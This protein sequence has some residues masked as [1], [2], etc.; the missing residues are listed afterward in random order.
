[1]TH[2]SPARGSTPSH[3]P[4]LTSGIL[5]AFMSIFASMSLALAARPAHA[6]DVAEFY[7]GKTVMLIVGSDAGGGYDIN[8]RVLAHYMARHIP[9]QPNIVV[10][11]MPGAIG[12]K[13]M[14]YIYSVAP[15]DG[16]VF[17]AAVNNMPYDPLFG[18]TASKFDTL[19]LNWLGSISKQTNVCLAWKGSRF[20]SLDDVTQH[21]MRVSGTGPAGWR[22]ML[23]L[24]FNSI[25]KTKF[26]VI[27]GYTSPG[28]MLAVER[29]EVDGICA[30]YATLKTAQNDWLENNKVTL[31]AQFGLT[32]LPGLDNVPMGL[33]RVT[34]PVD[35][36]ATRLFLSQQEFGRPYVMPPNVPT[37]RVAAMRAAFDATMKD[38][39]FLAEA[40]KQRLDVSP[41]TGPSMEALF[42]DGYNLPKDVVARTVTL[43]RSAGAFGTK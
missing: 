36:K 5:F 15:K 38:P 17:S 4:P 8:A 18:G 10:Q 30:D 29:G 26:E 24:L 33:D 31:L 12:I 25:A 42:K 23:P 34:D 32:R 3:M 11:N 40:A 21:T 16:T 14:N 2:E 22:S 9:G 43:L 13:A 28:S 41:L 19:K 7:K 37:E 6:D 1:M 39:A 27:N 20:K 35:H